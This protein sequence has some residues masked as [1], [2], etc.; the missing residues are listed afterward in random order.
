MQLIK[1][2]TQSVTCGPLK[3]TNSH[4]LHVFGL[5][6]KKS[7]E[8]FFFQFCTLEAPPQMLAHKSHLHALNISH[9]AQHKVPHLRPRLFAS[10][11]VKN[12]YSAAEV[13][14]VGDFIVVKFADLVLTARQ[15]RRS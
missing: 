10:A 1:R 13:A 7:V 14:A 2:K 4:R 3:Q 5:I 12:F 15:S 8:P 9:R 11:S 6:C